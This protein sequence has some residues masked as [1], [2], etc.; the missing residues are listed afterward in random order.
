MDEVNYVLNDTMIEC[1]SK[2]I[3]SF[4]YRCVYDIQFTHMEKLEKFF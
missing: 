3:R 4:E 1:K 2:F